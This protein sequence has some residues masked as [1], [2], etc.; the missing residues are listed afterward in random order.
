MV[1]TYH[2]LRQKNKPMVYIIIVN[3]NGLDDTLEC[4]ES[5][6]KINYPSYK[7]I[8]VDNG[9]KNNQAD[10]IK[11]KF[12]GVEL[13]KNETNEGFVI[14]NNQ[15]IKL[16]LEGGAQYL[17]LLNNDTT[18]KNDFLINLIKYAEQNNT[19]GILSPKILY[20]NSDTIWSMGGR[21]NC[22]AGFAIL[23]GK[24]KHREKYKTIIEPDYVTGCAMLIK[25]EVIKKI[26]LLDPVYFAYYEDGDFSFRAKKAG[27]NIRVIPESI[28][29][30]KKSAS[31]GIRGSKR[32]ISGLQ[33]Y[34]WARNGVIFGK[35]NL[36]G[37]KKFSF[38]FGHFSFNFIYHLLGN[39]NIKFILY[40]IKGLYHGV[41]ISCDN[42]WTKKK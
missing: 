3:W 14:A 29:W 4:L 19:V 41:I 40:Y 32:K 11:E 1:K 17:L 16:A 8:V 31:A 26:G 27:Y 28:I 34:L 15:G 6:E 20:Y 23:I 24:K 22:L 21:I 10:A 13:I 5:L 33:A 35:K 2:E 25:R 12:S 36:V 9:S 37:W 7:I 30:H 38:I 42:L 39:F 18:V